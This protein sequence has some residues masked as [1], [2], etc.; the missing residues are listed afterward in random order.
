MPP[1]ALPASLHAFGSDTFPSVLKADLERLDP[2]ALGLDRAVTQGGQVQ[3]FSVT[4]TLVGATGD[5]DAVRARVGVFFTE[6]VGGCSCGDDPYQVAGYREMRI[7][8]DRQTGAALFEL[9]GD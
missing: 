3:E 8:I 4:T 9:E 2:A 6:V 1:A 7:T 5:G